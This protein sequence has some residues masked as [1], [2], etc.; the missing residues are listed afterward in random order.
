[1]SRKS[2]FIFILIIL[3]FNLG[4]TN[5]I[6]K[7]VKRAMK[8]FDVV[9][10][11]VVIVKDNKIIHIKGYGY[12]AFGKHE[13][14][15]KNTLFAIASNS[16]AFTTAALSILV[17]EGKLSWKTKV[18]DI[19]PE[20]KMYNPYV[21]ENF[22]IEDLL[23]HRSGLG[24]GAGDLMFFPDGSDFSVNDILSVFQYF[25]PVSQFRTKFDYDNLLYIVAGEVIKR[26]SKMSWEEF[27]KNRIFK[28]LG[29]N[30]SFTNYY[31]IKDKNQL[32]K[33]HNKDFERLNIIKPYAFSPEKL[34]GA[35]GGI[36]SCVS[37]LAK[38]LI[39]QLNNGKTLNGKRIFSK[40]NHKKM[41]RIHTVLPVRE[42]KRYNTHFSGYGLGWVLK[43]IKGKMMV[44][45]TGGLPGYLSKTLLIPDINLGIVIL[46]NTSPGGGALFS[47][48]S[49]TIVDKYL[50]ISK[51]DWVKIYKKRFNKKNT[52]AKK[53]VK[54]VWKTINMNK[55][56]RIDI[57]KYKGV[58]K[59]KWFGKISINVK[60][61]KPYFMSYRSP[62]LKGELFYYKANTFVVKW[63]YR[64]MNADAFL[65]FCLD[66]DGNAV[67]FKMKGIS[68][69]IDFSF[70]FQDLNFI[71]L[72]N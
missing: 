40:K 35:A 52:Y 25:K 28:P 19:I 36:Y 37:D 31:D 4:F 51:R 1:M 58:Y 60:Q 33:P 32:A 54:N 26:V 69:E 46:T 62:K 42:D 61:G 9:G 64:D 71:K 11:A 38:W 67:G 23:T 20:F 24:L 22:I 66:E 2:F 34:N 21:S 16:K 13:F 15:D 65:M 29:M 55:N 53:V 45:H 8:E 3:L 5:S 41:W 43:D 10:T 49:Q 6:D 47:A 27:V 12:K 44:S 70:D 48:I 63:D 50:N 17:D 68:P 59:D 56:K 14:V 18:K 7:L 57:L 39:L 72:K 30:K